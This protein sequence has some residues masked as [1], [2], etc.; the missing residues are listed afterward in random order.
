MRP[1]QVE[2]KGD[3]I[4]LIEIECRPLNRWRRTG[5]CRH[6]LTSLAVGLPMRRL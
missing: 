6:I 3:I 2:A 1:L 5:W 4:E